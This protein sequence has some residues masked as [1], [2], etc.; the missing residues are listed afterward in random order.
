[1]LSKD[2]LRLINKYRNNKIIQWIFLLILMI[3]LS[4][5]MIAYMVK[6]YLNND[7]IRVVVL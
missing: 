6:E 7:T 3:I 5:I 1:M 2:E 4:G